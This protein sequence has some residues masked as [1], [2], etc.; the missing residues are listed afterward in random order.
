MIRINLLPVRAAQKKEKLRAQLSVLFLCLLF[1]GVGCGALYVTKQM[2]IDGVKAEIKDIDRQNTALKKKLGEVADYEKKKKDV[3]QKLA[4]LNDLK[5]AKTGPVHLM[6]ELSRALP[7]KVWLTD[8]TESGGKVS[9]SGIGETEMT[10]ASFMKNLEKSPYYQGVE[11]GVTEQKTVGGIK[12][13]QFSL[14]C[15][16]QKPSPN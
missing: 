4:V 16:T 10:V 11:L 1:V 2:D 13:Q 9:M 5:A 7:D 12:M 6:D 8:F 14:K 3:E 15:R